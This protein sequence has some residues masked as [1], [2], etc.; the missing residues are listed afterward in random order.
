MSEMRNYFVDEPL[1]TYN[2]GSSFESMLTYSDPGHPLK[3]DE[4]QSYEMVCDVLN[5]KPTPQRQLE[6]AYQAWKACGGKYETWAKACGRGRNYPSKWIE[7][8]STMT[9]EEVRK[10]CELF[11]CTLDYLQ[12]K[13]TRFDGHA[14]SPMT[15]KDLTS[16]YSHLNMEQK[17]VITNLILQFMAS[18]AAMRSANAKIRDLQAKIQ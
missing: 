6:E 16:M 17:Q 9:A 2:A 7:D 3:R 8:P 12:G 5:H 15:Q 4:N 10:T 1:H 14:D 11:G 18:N 13:S